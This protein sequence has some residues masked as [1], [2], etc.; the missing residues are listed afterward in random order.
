MENFIDS[1]KNFQES[2]DKV[3][4]QIPSMG[5]LG[6]AATSLIGMY[7]ISKGVSGVAGY[8]NRQYFRKTQDHY[9]KYNDKDS[10]VVITGG[11]DGIGL[12]YGR[13][14]AELGFNICVIA[15]SEDRL[16]NSC[17]EF[18]RIALEK[19]KT[20]KTKY[21]V[22]DFFHLT[23]FDQYKSIAD[24]IKDLD[25]AMLFLNAGTF[26]LCPLLYQKP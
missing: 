11:T 4:E 8:Y 25:I 26:T 20:I 17:S 9:A 10:W 3:S 24:Q 2:I 7:Q 12:Q 6:I 16:R 13:D 14:M 5:K 18:Q 22:A 1:F 19:K 21:V 23:T 15:R